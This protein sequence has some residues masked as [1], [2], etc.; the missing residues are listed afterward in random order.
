MVSRQVL[1]FIAPPKA[2]FPLHDDNPTQ[3]TAIVV[4]GLIL[5]NVLVFFYQFSLGDRQL[6]LWLR[7][8]ALIPQELTRQ[9]NR[10]WITLFS[11]QFLHGDL[12]H[13][14]FNMWFLYVFGNNIEDRL[15]HGKFIVFYLLC[16]V[17]AAVAQIMV[18]PTAMI[19]M[20]GASG[21]IAGLMGAYIVRFPRAKIYTLVFVGIFFTFLQI[22]AAVFLGIWFFFQTVYAA[23]SDPN[24]PGVA[25]LAHIG[26]FVAG[27]VL[28]LLIEHLFP[29]QEN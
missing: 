12:W 19:P 28:L 10:E 8:W 17:T 3:Q 6:I 7:D 22:P 27:V 21:S 11:Y 4:Y 2:M 26:G 20:V 29:K 18:S 5:V 13:L 14:L 1:R 25:Y 15:G 23:F 9:F 16:G 24:Q